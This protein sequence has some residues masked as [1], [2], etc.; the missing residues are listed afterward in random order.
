[1]DGIKEGR[2]GLGGVDSLLQTALQ[3]ARWACVTCRRNVH[4]NYRAFCCS[5]L[6]ATPVQSTCA[7]SV[8]DVFEFIL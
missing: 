2:G 8:E 1:M 7:A 4:I 3:I 6:V 5:V